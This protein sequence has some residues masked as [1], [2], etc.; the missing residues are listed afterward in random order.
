MSAGKGDCFEVHNRGKVLRLE[1]TCVQT[2]SW[3]SSAGQ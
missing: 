2:P 3:T 1:E